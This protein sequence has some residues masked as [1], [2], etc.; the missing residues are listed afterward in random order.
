MKTK[1]DRRRVK[2]SYDPD[3]DVLAL[4]QTDGGKIDHAREMGNMVVHFTKRGSPVLVEVLD[5][6][7]TFRQR[8]KPLKEFAQAAFVR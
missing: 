5:A 4:E 3:A 7:R 2:I 6:A 1:T 8:T